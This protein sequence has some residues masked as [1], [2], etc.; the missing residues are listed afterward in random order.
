MSENIAKFVK[1]MRKTY[2]LTQE[3]L[4]NKA[5]VGVRFIRELEAGKKTV[6]L[7]KVNI[8]LDLFGHTVGAVK[9]TVNM[10]NK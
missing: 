2:N 4:A 6:R 5:G 10:E 1:T 3:D 7:D 9:S 8:V